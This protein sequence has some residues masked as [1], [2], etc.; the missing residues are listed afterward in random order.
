MVSFNLV[1]LFQVSTA[2]AVIRTRIVTLACVRLQSQ[3]LRLYSRPHQP[4]RAAQQPAVAAA[5]C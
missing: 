5:R 1:T 2:V 3:Q 4:P